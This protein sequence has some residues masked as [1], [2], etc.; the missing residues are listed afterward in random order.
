MTVYTVYADTNDHHVISQNATYATARSGGGTK[1]DFPANTTVNMAQ[2]LSGG[3]YSC[4]EYFLSFDTSAIPA[5][6]PAAVFLDVYTQVIQTAPTQVI[7]FAEFAWTGGTADYIAG[8]SLSASPQFSRTFTGADSSAYKTTTTN[9][10][11]IAR[12][13]AYKLVC[14]TRNLRASTAPTDATGITLYTANFSGTAND[15]RIRVAIATPYT[16]AM[17]TGAFTLAGQAA[18]LRYGRKTAASAGSFAMT[19][20]D[21]LLNSVRAFRADQGSF[22]F[23]GMDARLRADRI[24]LAAAGVFALIGRAAALGIK[25]LPPITRTLV[26]PR[27]TLENG[28]T[29]EL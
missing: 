10:S 6:T 11:D 24:V 4:T 20:R 9:P 26:M 5:V 8:A 2:T 23:T 29:L 17:D 13:A 1:T 22:A 16:L 14:Y 19:G 15:P 12:D 21:A 7:D 18:S 28:R 27:S 25:R 3:T